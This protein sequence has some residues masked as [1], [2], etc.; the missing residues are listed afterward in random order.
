MP[1]TITPEHGQLDEAVSIKLQG[2]LARQKVTVQLKAVDLRGT[3]WQSEVA[4]VANEHGVIDLASHV[5]TKGSYKEKD[6]MGLFWSLLPTDKTK[7]YLPFAVSTTAPMEYQLSALTQGSEIAATSLVRHASKEQVKRIEIDNDSV[8]GVLYQPQTDE[9]VPAVVLIPGSTGLQALELMASLLA[10]HGYAVLLVGYYRYKDLPDEMYELPLERFKSAITWLAEQEW[11]DIQ[12]LSAI[13]VS[14]GAEALLATTA[15]FSTLPLKQLIAISPSN[16]VWQG[17]GKGRPEPRSSWSLFGEP[18]SYLPLHTISAAREI[19]KRK[20]IAKLGLEG[21]CA[22][23][24][25]VRFK[26]SYQK[27]LKGN[28]HLVEQAEIPVEKIKAPITFFVG[29]EDALWPAK[30]MVEKM[31]ARLAE[32]AFSYP[33]V[34]HSYPGVGHVFLP[35]GIPANMTQV[36]LPHMRLAFGGRREVYGK[37]YQQYW[38]D[39]LAVLAG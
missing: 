26:A 13:G 31:Q 3:H 24:D 19:L 37:A 34:C 12:Q 7:R 20:A 8:C 4:F 2:L 5:P 22:G 23:C 15:Y 30:T 6:A 9:A 21:L 1:F 10:S 32:H 27:A 16:V 39:L 28:K 38:R 29:D 17:I 25:A 33:V 18:L 36:N 14:K 11:V 35:A